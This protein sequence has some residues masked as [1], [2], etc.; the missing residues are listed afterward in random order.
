[1]WIT[2]NVAART[3]I[4]LTAV[5]VPVQSLPAASCGCR[6]GK[7]SWQEVEQSKG[8]C[9]ATSS[10]AAQHS[11][12]QERSSGPCRCTGAKVC[13]C[14]DTSPC[15][16]KTQSCCAGRSE[17]RTSSCCSSRA[18]VGKPVC[19]CGTNCRCSMNKEPVEP[20]APLPVE[21]ASVEKV[22]NDSVS[23]VSLASVCQ[24][25]A[26]RRTHDASSVTDALAVLDY[27]TTLCRFTI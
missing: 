19:L 27:C 7:G 25:P 26:A 8:C 13:R 1:M 10:S 24:R 21:N 12:C 22:A 3:I 5:T 18:T 23:T 20:A 15:R 16:Q 2:N 14:G 11:C 4:W 6:G 17:A 9:C